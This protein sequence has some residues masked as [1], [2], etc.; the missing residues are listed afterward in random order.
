MN[1]VVGSSL[2][3]AVLMLYLLIY[4]DSH[5]ATHLDHFS[6]KIFKH[7]IEDLTNTT[8]RNTIISPMSIYTMLA[9]LGE[10]AD[11]DTRRQIETAL[12]HNNDTDTDMK[13]ILHNTNVENDFDEISLAKL[14]LV[15]V[16]DKFERLHILDDIAATDYGIDFVDISFDSKTSD[17]VN[18]LIRNKSHD[19]IVDAVDDVDFDVFKKML[20]LDIVHFHGRWSVPFDKN[21]TV[22]MPF[23]DH[24]YRERIG[25]VEMMYSKYNYSITY[26]KNLE[27]RIIELPYSP[28]VSMYLIMPIKGVTVNR[29][30]DI[31]TN[32]TTLFDV[33][34][35]FNSIIEDYYDD[36]DG[37]NQIICHIPKFVIENVNDFTDV[38]KNHFGIGDLFSESE[39]QL[40]KLA[41]TPLHVSTL[42]QQTIIE[43]D[44]DGTV[45]D[46]ATISTFSDRIAIPM[47][48]VNRPFIFFIVNKTSRII[49]FEGAYNGPTKMDFISN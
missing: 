9:F 25:F 10:S 19:R 42:K 1:M 41:V 14:N 21:K 40:P 2:I 35:D 45:A 23:Y 24:D 33:I 13:K 31:L 28:T 7:V 11:G 3:V 18:V 22:L 48:T 26:M 8:S 12:G 46:A 6:L 47:F 34:D 49:L 30:V 20:L 17:L 16:N 39:S 29:V 38:L 27:S 4:I 5:S 37:E 43:I 32:I 36:Y 15:I 44:E